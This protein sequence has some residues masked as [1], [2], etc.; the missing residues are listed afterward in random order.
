MKITKYFFY[1][2]L[3]LGAN[4]Q[5]QTYYPSDQLVKRIETSAGENIPGSNI[6]F[7]LTGNIGIGSTIPKEK[8]DIKFDIS[9]N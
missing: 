1:F 9:I 5:A 2:L 7:N 6:F 4:L 3:L 8:L